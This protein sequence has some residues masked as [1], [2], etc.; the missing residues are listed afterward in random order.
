MNMG[1][2]PAEAESKSYNQEPRICTKERGMRE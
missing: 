1:E 2:H